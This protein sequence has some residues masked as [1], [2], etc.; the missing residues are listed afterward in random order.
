KLL[1][2]EVLRSYVGMERIAATVQSIQSGKRGDL[3]IAS[4]PALAEGSI[5]RL[6]GEFV[7]TNPEVRLQVSLDLQ[8]G[9]LRALELEL[10]DLGFLFGPVSGHPNIDTVA[11]GTRRMLVAL[12]VDH[13][14]ALKPSLR[15]EDL[16]DE[17]IILNNVP[18]PLRSI[19]DLRFFEAARKPMVSCEAATQKAVAAMIG[20]GAG[21][22]FID[23]E[24]AN[25]IDSRVVATVPLEPPVTWTIQTARNK[26]RSISGPLR[27][28]LRSIRIGA[29]GDD[30]GESE[31]RGNVRRLH[32]RGL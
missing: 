20:A 4:I 6:L 11:I 13:S 28:L 1:Y 2:E 8:E 22:G 14:L 15:I 5:G 24:V 25:Q 3:R 17:R 23:S 18:H 21:I 10:A 16:V 26:Q 12:P 7:R 19:V 9:V 27:S 32:P 30:A 31:S 29:T